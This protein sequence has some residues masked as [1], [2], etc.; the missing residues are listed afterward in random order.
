MSNQENELAWHLH[1]LSTGKKE[2][3]SRRVC[4]D[5]HKAFHVHVDSGC[6]VNWPRKSERTQYPIKGDVESADYS[7]RCT[8][9]FLKARWAGQPGIERRLLCKHLYEGIESGRLIIVGGYLVESTKFK[10]A[11]GRLIE[12]FMGDK[13]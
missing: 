13:K 1:D 11:R 5:V 7:K 2:P 9:G 3:Q 8:T 4:Y 6:W 10:V 12:W